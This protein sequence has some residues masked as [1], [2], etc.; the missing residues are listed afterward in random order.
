MPVRRA[1]SRGASA[2]GSKAGSSGS[3]AMWAIGAGSSAPSGRDAHVAERPLV[4]EAQV[5][6]VVV[7]GEQD[8]HV[9]GQRP[10]RLADE[11]LAAHAQV[12]EQGV[13]ARRQPQVLA[14]APGAVQAAPGQR[15]LEV[16]RAGQMAAHRARVQDLDGLDGPADDV[17]LQA[18]A[19]GLDLGQLRH[20][21]LR[22]R[23][24]GRRWPARPIRH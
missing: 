23:P 3:G 5:G 18:T 9:R 12:R 17:V 7:E 11:Q 21:V 10:V 22:L 13:L 15:G 16:G 2:A 1:R 24:A 14:P 19:D 20:R 6:T 4:G 8:P